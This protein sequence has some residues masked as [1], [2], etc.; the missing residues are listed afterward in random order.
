MISRQFVSTVVRHTR[1]VYAYN[2]VKRTI[3]LSA[4]RMDTIMSPT[5]VD[6][7][8]RGIVDQVASLTLL[9]VAELNRALKET[10]NIPDAPVMAF[11]SGPAS[12][13]SANAEEEDGDNA[14]TVQ[15]AFSLK[16]TKFDDT[17]KVALI[18]EVKS[19]VEGLNLV[20]AK[21]FVESVPQIVK[22]NISKDEAEKLKATLE[23]SGATCVI[24]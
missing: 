10:L 21:K 3:S 18:K 17:K 4:A 8:I 13:T 22:S 23:A 11:A 15:T 12:P 24:D 2:V 5:E 7:K 14:K 9:E 20:Q 16:I 1:N 19:V 6:P